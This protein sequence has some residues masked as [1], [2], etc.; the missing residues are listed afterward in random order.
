M[1]V[2]FVNTPL[3]LVVQFIPAP[4][5]VA[6]APVMDTPPAFEQAVWLL[7]AFAVG[8]PT[9]V[10]TFVDVALAHGELPTAVSVNVTLPAVI[11]AALGVY[12]G[13]NVVPLVNVPVPLVPQLTLA[14][15]VAL[16]PVMLTEAELVHMD[17]LPPATAVAALDI[18]N[19]LVDEALAQGET[20]VA[21][22]VNVTIPAVISAG[23][24]V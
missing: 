8:V 1:V 23:L 21:V 6:V 9:I 3:P 4:V 5:L 11:S 17:W 19:V 22:N 12:V 16:A 14:W 7:P 10:N 2:P 20:A 18:V 15:L 24:G 13:V